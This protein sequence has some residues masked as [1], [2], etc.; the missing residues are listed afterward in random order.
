MK[1]TLVTITNNSDLSP[2][3][4]K[5][6]YSLRRSGHILINKTRYKRIFYAS[7]PE[8]AH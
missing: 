4:L 5:W 1:F 7:H 2:N 8:P 6:R 3:R